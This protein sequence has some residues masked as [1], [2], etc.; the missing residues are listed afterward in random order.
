MRERVVIPKEEAAY[1]AVASPLLKEVA[2]L[3][4]DT[5]MRPDELHRMQWQEITWSGARHGTIMITTGKATAARRQ[6]PMTK[7][8]PLVLEYGWKTQGKRTEGWA[9]SSAT[10]TGHIDHSTV[11]KQ[12]RKALKDSKVSP[13]VLYSLRHT[14][15]TR[16]GASGCDVWTLMRA[17]GHSSIAIS[18]RYVH[19]HEDSVL[20]AVERI[21]VSGS[22][23][24]RDSRK[25]PRREPAK[26]LS[27]R[28]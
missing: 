9:W 16:L 6:I 12:H 15:L 20:A 13:F 1:L 2:T 23:N 28:L 8:V 3:L 14:F 5:G 25:R 11:K 27:V 7:R 19:P 17:A 21:A 10:R 18:S 4:F 22:D 26:K 24:F